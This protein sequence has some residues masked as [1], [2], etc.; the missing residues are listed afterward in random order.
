MVRSIKSVLD[1][2]YLSKF[3][4]KKGS[5]KETDMEKLLFIEIIYKLLEADDRRAL[6]ENI[7]LDLHE[8]DNLYYQ[9]VHNLF[10]L[11]FTEKQIELIDFYVY[12]IPLLEEAPSTLEVL[13]GR[14]T[15][16]YNFETP[17][18]LWEVLKEIK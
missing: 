16:N 4:V 3:R 9:I 17:E 14:K 6:L 10:K 1:K 11:H 18:D 13:K 2:T 7:G 8:Y 5:L 15:V 12:E